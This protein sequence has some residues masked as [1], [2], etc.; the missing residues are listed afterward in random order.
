MHDFSYSQIS[1]NYTADILRNSARKK[2][3]VYDFLKNYRRK[4]LLGH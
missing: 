1:A 2:W 3:L 4:I